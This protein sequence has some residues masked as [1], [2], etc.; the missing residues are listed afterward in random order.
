M[1][2]LSWRQLMARKKQTLL[3]LLGISF[4]TML[5]VAISGVQLGMREYIADQLL[6]NTAHILIS[7]AENKIDNKDITDRFYG[8]DQLVDWIRPPGGKRDT[9]RLKNYPGWAE[10][11]KNNPSVF[12]FS[13]RL[14]INALASVG[15]FSAPVSIVGT[16]PDKHQRITSIASYMKQGKFTDLKGG[17]N[18]VILGSKVMENL[19]LRLGD[20]VNFSAAR[21][22]PKPFKVVGVVHFGNEQIDQNMAFANLSNVQVLN[23]TPGRVSEISVALMDENRSEEIAQSW[24]L[25]SEDKVEDWREANKMFMEMIKMQD[26]VRYFIT[27]AI[28]LVAAFGVYNVLSIM[29]NQRKKEIAILRSIG[30]G[31]KRILE[32][33]VFQGLIL[34]VSGG[35]L[36][37][38]LGFALSL[39]VSS[40][41]LGFEIG[42]SSS[43]P[44]SFSLSTYVIAFVAALL[45]SVVS[46]YLPAHSASRLSPMDIIREQ[47]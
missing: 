41:D 23:K 20:F 13:P 7:G 46:S 34:G 22:Q 26:F 10:R 3:I 29:I 14:T 33:V 16:L 12:D 21:G 9:S 44:V 35:V 25:L 42:Q 19:S 36:G 15:K 28:L 47:A 38:T 5:F 18:K 30:Y 11:L 40:I 45:A 17:A 2:F 43:L 37:L 6:N 32:L 27:F 24:K 4:G 31:P 39:W 8:I 1:F